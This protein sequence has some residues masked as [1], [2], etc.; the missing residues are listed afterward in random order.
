MHK[1]TSA[2]VLDQIADTLVLQE[3]YANKED[4]LHA[5]AR[6]AVREKI[7]RYRRR[8]RR[9][10]QKCTMD[11]AAFTRTL[12]GIVTPQEEDDWLSWHAA[13]GMLADWQTVYAE[14]SHES[15]RH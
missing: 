1:T 9:F 11:F 2:A 5:L 4:A 12:K 8:I 6:T 10:Q 15:V 3:K 7:T 13:L 14:L